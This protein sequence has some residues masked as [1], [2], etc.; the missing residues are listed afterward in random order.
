MLLNAHRLMIDKAN[1]KNIYRLSPIQGGMLFHALYDEGET[2]YFEQGVY[3]LDGPVNVSA[4]KRAWNS[5]V[6]RHDALRTAFVLK[7]VPEPLQV[8]LRERPLDIVVHDLSNDDELKARDRIAHYRAEDKSK[9]FDLT[10]DPLLRM[11]LFRLSDNCYRMVMSFHHIIMDGWCQGILA[12]EFVA[13]YESIVEDRP[14]RLP[15]AP[16]YRDFIRWL[17]RQ[18]K[19]K[20]L[21]FWRDRLEGFVQ[22]THFP[23]R[24]DAAARDGTQ[25]MIT[26]SLTGE[27]TDTLARLAAEAGVTLGTI[28]QG[29][30]GVL[31]GKLNGKQDAVFLATVSGRPSDLPNAG[32]IVG[33]FINAVPVRVRFDEA[34]S[35][36]DVLTRLHRENGES[37]PF[38][39]APLAEIQAASVLKRDLANTLLVFENYPFASEK[40]EGPFTITQEDI[41]EQTHY[42]LTVQVYPGNELGFGVAFDPAQVEEDLVVGLAQ[43]FHDAVSTLETSSDVPARLLFPDAE[44]H[45]LKKHKSTEEPKT[46]AAVVAATF[47]AD[48]VL[49]DLHWWLKKAGYASQ[50]TGAGYNQVFQEL[51]NPDSALSTCDGYGL[52]LVRFEDWIRDLRHESDQNIIQHLRSTYT[53]YLESLERFNGKALLVHVLLPIDNAS[54][55]EQVASVLHELQDAVTNDVNAIGNVLLLDARELASQ[56]AIPVPF[57]PVADEA[58]HVPYSVEMNHAIGA[59][60]ARKVLSRVQHSFKVIAVD[61]D[62]TLWDGIV[63]EDGVDGCRV[64]G[65]YRMLQEFLVER[66][67]EGFLI[68]LNSKNNENDVWEVFDKNPD[69]I[70][71]REHVVAW[72]I[73]W[74]PK[75]G[76]LLEM[77][78][79]LNLGVDSFIFIDDSGVECAEVREN[80]PTVLVLQVP[81][82]HEAIPRFLEHVWAFDKWQVTEEDRKRSHMYV[83]ERGRQQEQKESTSLDEFLSSLDLNIRMAP[84]GLPQ[85]PRASQLTQRTNQFNIST[86]RRDES[87]IKVLME[88]DRYICWIVT[89]EDRFGEYGIVGL[90]LCCREENT[91]SVDTLLLSCRVLGRGVEE[92]ILTG[93]RKY[94]EKYGLDQIEALFVPTKKNAPALQFLETWEG[95]RIEREDDSILFCRSVQSLPDGVPFGTFEYRTEPLP[96]AVNSMSQERNT[97]D[98]SLP[99]VDQAP[100]PEQSEPQTS[101]GHS[102][103]ET[104]NVPQWEIN[105]DELTEQDTLLHR[106]YYFPLAY[107]TGD[108]L[109]ALPEYNDDGFV[110]EGYSTDATASEYIPPVTSEQRSLTGLF[111]RVLRTEAVGLRDNFFDR[112]G[113]SLSAVELLSGIHR[114][115]K[116][117][118]SLRAIFDNPTPE[119]LLTVL[120][121]G[122]SQDYQPIERLPKLY[123]YDLS[124][125]QRRLWV[126]DNIQSDGSYVMGGANMLKGELD[127]PALNK[128]FQNVI[129]RHE[130]LRTGII[131]VHG[132]PRQRVFDKV[133]FQIELVDLSASEG[134]LS[135]KEHEAMKVAKARERERFDLASPPLVRATLIKLG[136]EHHV[137]ALF[138][139]HIVGDGWS[140]PIF[141][142]ELVLFY[143]AHLKGQK[144]LDALLPPL[145]IHYK[146]YAVWQKNRLE[147]EGAKEDEAFWLKKLE[148]PL[149]VLELPTDFPRS[150]NPT[151]DGESYR[152]LLEPA[153]LEAVQ[154]LCRK[155]RAT[156]FMFLLASVRSLLWNYTRQTDTVIGV[157]LAGRDHPDLADQIGF[158]VNTLPLRGN[159]NPDA[160][161][162]E[163]LSSVREEVL[164]A[165]AHGSYPF[166]LIVN[167]LDGLERDTGR[168][169]VFDVMVALQNNREAEGSIEGLAITPFGEEAGAGKFDLVFNFN[170]VNGGLE[171][172]LEYRSSLYTE[173]TI[174]RIG[175]SLVRTLQRAA[176]VPEKELREIVTSY[177]QARAASRIVA[178]TV[179]PEGTLLDRFAETVQRVASKT[180]LWTRDEVISYDELDDR[181]NAIASALVARG[182]AKNQNVAVLLERGVDLIATMLGVMKTG[183]LYLPIDPA[184]PESRIA[185]ILEDSRAVLTVVGENNTTTWSGEHTTLKALLERERTE[186]N[187]PLPVATSEDSAY[188]IYTS[189]STGK[190]KGV[191]VGHSS[192]LNMIHRQIETF[193]LTDSDKVLQ[194]ASSAFDAS[195]SE[196]FMTLL[197]GATLVLPSADDLK[198]T[199]T[200]LKVMEEAEVTVATIP[201]VYLRAL[202]CHPLPCLRALITAGEEAPVR[203]VL[204]Y[205]SEGKQVFN[206]YGPT[207][208]SVCA[209]IHQLDP[210]REYGER[211]PVGNLIEG[212]GGFIAD[213]NLWPLPSGA[214]GELVLYGHGLAK[215][216]LHNDV[217]T[218]EKFVFPEWLPNVR[219]YR[220]GDRVRLNASGELDFLGRIDEQVKIRGHRVEPEEARHAM[221][222]LAGVQ[223]A[224]VIPLGEPGNKQ[225][226]GFVCGDVSL[227]VS[228]MRKDLIQELPPFLVPQL[229]HLVEIMP[230]TPN[231]KV[232]RKRLAQIHEQNVG[233]SKDSNHTSGPNTEEEAVL[234]QAMDEVLSRRIESVHEDFFA[235]GGDSIK[236]IQVRGAL[237]RLGYEVRSRD[238]Y[239]GLTIAGIAPFLKPLGNEAEDLYTEGTVFS[240]PVIDWF[241]ERLTLEGQQ[242]FVL[243]LVVESASPVDPLILEHALADILKRHPALRMVAEVVQSRIAARI[244]PFGTDDNVSEQSIR[245]VPVDVYDLKNDPERFAASGPI[246]DS[247]AKS[248]VFDGASPLLRPVLLQGAQKDRLILVLHHLV[249][250]AISQGVL[251]NDLHIA[252]AARLKGEEPV[253]GAKSASYG[254]W[255]QSLDEYGRS[256]PE[257]ELEE[258][259]SVALDIR[260]T[261]VPFNGVEARGG[262]V[263]SEGQVVIQGGT[264]ERFIQARRK[265]IEVHH[266]LLVAL[267][268]TFAELRGNQQL[269][270]LME[271]HGRGGEGS[272]DLTESV[273]WF[274]AVYP[275]LID[276]GKENVLEALKDVR[277]TLNRVSGREAD[278]GIAR[279]CSEDSALQN[280]LNVS[281]HV[282]FN[283]LGEILSGSAPDKTKHF[284]YSQDQPGGDHQ[285]LN[286]FEINAILDNDVIRM[287]YSCGEGVSEDFAETFKKEFEDQIDVIVRALDANK[288]EMRLICMP[289]AGGTSSSYDALASELPDT[290]ETLALELPGHGKRIDEKPLD[291]VPEIVDDILMQLESCADRPYLL[292]GHS[293]GALMGFE[294][295]R[296]LVASGGRYRLPQ[297]LVCSG[298]P[299]PFHLKYGEMMS[300]LPDYEFIR[301]YHTDSVR[302][303]ETPPTGDVLEKMIASTRAD[304]VAVENYHY[305]EAERTSDTACCIAGKRRVH[306]CRDGARL[307]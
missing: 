252:Y 175:D 236:A 128:A 255:A 247:A 191:C 103:A 231:G 270:V 19:G 214:F 265:G 275:V 127:L 13:A 304:Y 227:D 130:S 70:L 95:E 200:F 10:S 147:S 119:A 161:F 300:E 174:A 194:F 160:S 77:A 76:N 49:P 100:K 134:S 232:D 107:N 139:H 230:A 40:D 15:G 37:G 17:E 44:R 124:H 84:V 208:C 263:T 202:N 189:G 238:I 190:P 51:L 33:L 250:D 58:G 71:R 271:S 216:Y 269:A 163:I 4:F 201:P 213:E 287:R 258:W 32:D 301:A 195:L 46:I 93:M 155:E 206:A 171:C 99:I 56:Y 118:I 94:A 167:K 31:L 159:I 235:M 237:R 112:G 149:P 150:A 204:F 183:A 123:H 23:R 297:L 226:I 207:E 243:P 138:M 199:E 91:L 279:Y 116:T 273:G 181:A 42:D 45:A 285:C 244:L 62:N 73:N 140:Y 152:I 6:E 67:R 24:R 89:V 7:G 30:W 81:K 222:E 305:S 2:H 306:Y 110:G 41:D 9:G 153:S 79:E 281:P 249:V 11:A 105:L 137:L 215:G 102:S 182:I 131:L 259:R 197:S 294:V 211:I 248:F 220:T 68:V 166:D 193:G 283:Y 242:R 55:S 276:G 34:Q 158:Y 101:S 223:D 148:G 8:V 54:C 5:I 96:S 86:V 284:H 22:P 162:A 20:A 282:S 154:E 125:A 114:E 144:D 104:L 292:F 229:I 225:L 177:N 239:E 289:V 109:P 164:D 97:S 122:E 253:F 299:A 254:A 47:T 228:A 192:F 307:G 90:L 178:D 57:D 168:S 203:D 156:L 264:A 256:I 142:R 21:D 28:V 176:A 172:L 277:T 221:L 29:L 209:T 186:K 245:S 286:P 198:D 48:P 36:T 88:D 293:L 132:E 60:L 38:Q 185:M 26:F 126:L 113:H 129:H 157:P 224:V 69:M 262:S 234:V 98:D 115:F 83:A 268:R 66:Y 74:R 219:C 39:F 82:N 173:E 291:T 117:E 145:D 52:L 251:L 65:G 296:K 218:E 257:S 246:L 27:E 170:E 61:C 75:S 121:N 133:D 14:V 43:W 64:F 87:E 280:D 135:E 1:V 151:S 290:F 233:S 272:L 240:T 298:A 63:G 212:V 106:F 3:R 266:I 108:Q 141:I 53:H 59:V 303:G 25:Q 196:V 179:I 205:A 50:I 210:A 165:F 92:A 136:E 72:R 217:L 187:L 288:A 278:Y 184:W 267:A 241:S 180:A 188:V 260:R 35:L 261:P 146:D 274:T 85:V 169:P 143:D 111:E 302:R 18:D 120:Q 295:A 80:A 16:Q 12:R 78:D